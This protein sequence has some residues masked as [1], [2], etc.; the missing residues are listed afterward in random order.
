ML[1]DCNSTQLPPLFCKP[2]KVNHSRELLYTHRDF[3]QNTTISFRSLELDTDIDMLF[4]W[5]NKP[6]SKRFWQLNGSKTLLYNT[7][8]QTLDNPHAHSYIGCFNDQPVCQVDLYLIG[9]D[10]L[11]NHVEYKPEDCGLH[12][13]MLP[14]QQSRKGLSEV[15][16]QHFIRFFFSFPMASRLYAEPDRGNILANRLAEKSGFRF[17]KP[18]TLSYKTASLYLITKQIFHETYRNP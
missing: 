4:D 12:L 3:P 11:K 7:C 17:Q 10:E 13:L 16:L 2:I 5:V 1:P 18:I 15:M 9:A 14:P 6:Y 8:L